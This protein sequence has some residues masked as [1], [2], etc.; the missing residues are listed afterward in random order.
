MTE[1]VQR[2][3]G[4]RGT[5]QDSG[6]NHISSPFYKQHEQPPQIFQ[7]SLPTLS[8]CA[9]NKTLTKLS[10]SENSTDSDQQD[11]LIM[12]HYCITMVPYEEKNL[13]HEAVRN[14]QPPS[15]LLPAGGQ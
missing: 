11:S 1:N 13:L 12:W 2:G 10:F 4:R 7:S 9:I 14:H 6:T 15:H 5:E 8:H 3:A